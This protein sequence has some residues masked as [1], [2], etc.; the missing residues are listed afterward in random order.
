[1]GVAL[2][3]VI[4]RF[5]ISVLMLTSSPALKGPIGTPS[6]SMNW[7]TACLKRTSLFSGF[8]SCLLFT[9]AA[10]S[11]SY[12]SRDFTSFSNMFRSWASM[13]S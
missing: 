12:S 11:R 5:A 3:A 2:F 13:F 1:M 4:S 9:I 6:G 10:T 8:F 7:S